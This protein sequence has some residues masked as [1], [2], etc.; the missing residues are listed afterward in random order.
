MEKS[1]KCRVLR[2]TK[3]LRGLFLFRSTGLGELP[4]GMSDEEKLKLLEEKISLVSSGFVDKVSSY[5]L[6]PLVR[7]YFLRIRYTSALWLLREAAIITYLSR[8]YDKIPSRT[9]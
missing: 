8:N 4:Q 7:S 6:L 5:G 1:I 2:M 9:P 3:F